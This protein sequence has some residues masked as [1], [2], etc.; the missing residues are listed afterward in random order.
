[1]PF[2]KKK[3]FLFFFTFSLSYL[4][5][6][7]LFS[8]SIEE[9]GFSSLSFLSAQASIP[10]SSKAASKEAVLINGAGASFPF[11]IYS[12]WIYSY[13]TQ[14]PDI[15]INYQSIGSGGGIRQFLN[16]TVDFGASD[17]PMKNSELKR[18]KIPILHIPTVLGA[19]VIIY[20][21]PHL[22]EELSLT[23]QNVADIFSGKIKKW[24]DPRLTSFNSA[25][26]KTT[27]KDI[28]VT[29]RSDGSGSTA[30]FTDYLS[31][32]VSGWKN[33]I[34]QGKVV[35]WP[36]GIGAKGNEGVAGMVKQTPGSVGY[37]ELTYAHT[38][39]LSMALIQN[40]RG[41]FIKASLESI[42]EASQASLLDMPKDFR[43]SI[44]NVEGQKAYPISS[45]TYFLVY[46][47]MNKQKGQKLISFINWAL[48]EGQ[49]QAPKL[50]YAPLPKSL[51]K[52]IQLRLKEIQFQ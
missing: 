46:K 10:S 12:K 15:K 5:F 41:H 1:M 29:Y 3:T 7:H 48:T 4:Y 24:N 23:A 6:I 33:E 39:Q 51:T 9:K 13:R 40:K 2:Q 17:A 34:G 37:V 14:H 20:N 16:K 38:N 31:K 49:K 19:I 8:V 26:K 27:I 21:L 42:T 43:V 47:K 25:L 52:K 32:A 44:T 35:R 22:K 28:L 30:V 11:P 45:Y 36:T 18:S 50:S